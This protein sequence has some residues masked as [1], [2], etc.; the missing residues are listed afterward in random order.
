MPGAPTWG[1]AG[2]GKWPQPTPTA[3]P[4]GGPEAEAPAPGVTPY[5][6]AGDEEPT[7]SFLDFT[8]EPSGEDETID[9]Q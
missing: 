3:N 4:Y 1:Y 8:E 9:P 5:E 6:G 2:M 7:A